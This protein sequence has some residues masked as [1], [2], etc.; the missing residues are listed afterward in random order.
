MRTP[1]T[2]SANNTEQL[3]K[4]HWLILQQS[5]YTSKLTLPRRKPSYSQN[6]ALTRLNPALLAKVN[7][8]K[9]TYVSFFTLGLRFLATNVAF[10]L[11]LHSRQHTQKSIQHENG[12]G[13]EMLKGQ[14]SRVPWPGKSAMP[15]VFQP[16]LWG[17]QQPHQHS[18]TLQLA[19]CTQ[20]HYNY[21]Q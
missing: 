8:F 20:I 15:L 16:A 5:D 7:L 10:S 4:L 13:L 6:Q 18:Y 21:V 14:L 1:P 2:F 12:W 9:Q 19:I 17:L 3:R 11:S